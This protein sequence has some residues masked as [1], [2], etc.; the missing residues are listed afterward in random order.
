M[1]FEYLK[2]SI[3][4]III[5]K[6]HFNNIMG[7]FILKLY[8]S[9]LCFYTLLKKILFFITHT[10][11]DRTMCIYLISFKPFKIL[12]TCLSD[13][14]SYYFTAVLEGVFW[15]KIQKRMG[16]KALFS[17]K[18][19]QQQ[20]LRKVLI[21]YMSDFV[22]EQNTF[23]FHNEFMDSWGNTMDITVCWHILHIGIY[24]RYTTILGFIT[25]LLKP[26]IMSILDNSFNQPFYYVLQHFFQST[27]KHLLYCLMHT[28][29]IFLSPQQTVSSLRVEVISK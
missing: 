17:L 22:L 28:L 23:Q 1:S 25:S 21:T 10:I 6:N 5:C 11:M 29:N 26:S 19:C 16:S 14:I 12:L 24:S 13:F 2:I 20:H 18:P 9:V 15:G 4:T 7:P 3:N 8:C 27:V